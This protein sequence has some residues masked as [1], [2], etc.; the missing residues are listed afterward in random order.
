MTQSAHGVVFVCTLP[1]HD[2][3][4][5]IYLSNNR[6]LVYFVCV[7]TSQWSEYGEVY[8]V[9]VQYINYEMQNNFTPKNPIYSSF[10]W[11]INC[12]QRTLHL[13]CNYPGCKLGIG[14]KLLYLDL[15][16]QRTRTWPES[17]RNIE[18][19]YGLRW[20]VLTRREWV[21][22]WFRLLWPPSCVIPQCTVR[23]ALLYSHLARQTSTY[24][25][26]QSRNDPVLCPS[27]NQIAS[28]V[29][30]VEARPPP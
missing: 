1:V 27:F 23:V 30:A 3:S 5:F 21:A 17:K 4:S 6:I 26:Y 7:T 8:C 10:L 11:N 13:K 19:T 25:K 18:N 12:L 28:I 16:T 14:V 20:F 2:V 29:I 22:V 9:H 15:V 24:S